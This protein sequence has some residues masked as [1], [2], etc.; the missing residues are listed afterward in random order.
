METPDPDLIGECSDLN[1]ATAR[2]SDG[3]Q[4]GPRFGLLLTAAEPGRKARW[5]RLAWSAY[6]SSHT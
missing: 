2:T 4:F 1:E 3:N 5:E 6:Q